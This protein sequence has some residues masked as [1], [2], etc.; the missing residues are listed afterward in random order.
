MD[1]I[2]LKLPLSLLAYIL[3]T[4]IVNKYPSHPML[5][6]GCTYHTEN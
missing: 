6:I 2:L 4:K 5:A 3:K 1:I